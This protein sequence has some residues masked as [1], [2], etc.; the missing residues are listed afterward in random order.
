[1]VDGPIFAPLSYRRRLLFVPNRSRRGGSALLRTLRAAKP[2]STR[3]S[4]MSAH[5]TIPR[6]EKCSALLEATLMEICA[7]GPINVHPSEIC[8][9]LGLSKALVNYHFGGRDGLVTEA[10]EQGYGR[11]VDGLQVAADGA[12]DDPVDRLFAW[13]E[14]QVRWTIENP[15]LAAASTFR[16]RLA[17]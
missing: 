3:V 17:A 7:H 6:L 13:F 14:A 11:Y 8:E 5:I 15:G 4:A 12:G 2:P 10:M 1:M 9:G 16:L